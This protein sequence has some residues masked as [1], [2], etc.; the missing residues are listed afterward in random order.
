MNPARFTAKRI[1]V[2]VI[3]VMAASSCLAS[4]DSLHLRNGRHLQGKYVGG[5]TS[6]IGFMTSGSVEYFQTSDVLALMFDSNVESPVNGLQPNHMNGASPQM[7][8]PGTTRTI[9]VHPRR[10]GKPQSRPELKDVAALRY[11]A[12]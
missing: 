6:M 12:N 3:C 10:K 7:T 1:C 2:I 11:V 5:S 8:L 9:S 4:A